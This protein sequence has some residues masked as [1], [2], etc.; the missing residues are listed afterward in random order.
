LIQQTLHDEIARLAA[1]PILLV[2]CDY[3]GT[4]A[5]IAH[6]PSA[7]RTDERSLAALRRLATLESTHAAVISGRARQD[8][9]ERLGI[10]P[11]LALIGGHGAEMGAPAPAIAESASRGTAPL[12]FPDTPPAAPTEPSP[13]TIERLSTEL[14]HIAADFPGA[15]VETKPS[16]AAFHYRKVDPESHARARELVR[17]AA[18]RLKAPVVREGT[19]VIEVSLVPTNKGRAFRWL[20]D[21]VYAH[22]AVFIGDDLTDEDAFAVLRPGDLGVK[23]GED[24]S[25]ARERIATTDDVHDLLEAL[26]IARE[27]WLARRHLP[28]IEDHAHLSDQRTCA[29]IDPHG[30]IVWLCAPRF[31]SPPIFA[32][33]LGG[34]GAMAGLA[35]SHAHPG[36]GAGGSAAGGGAGFFEI[37]P[38]DGRQPIRRAYEPDTFILKTEYDG[39]LTVTDYLD[40][41]AGRPYQRAGRSDL[42]RV[43]QA[44]PGSESPGESP[45]PGKIVIRFSPRIDFARS[46]T[47]LRA[48]A[49]GLVI[50]GMLDPAALYVPGLDWTIQDDGPNQTAVTTVDLAALPN[51]TLTLELRLGTTSLRV[52]Q[53]PEPARREATRY[54]WTAWAKP[55]R[56]PTLHTDLVKRSALVLKSLCYGPTGAICAAGT[57]SLPEQLGGVRN[58]DYRFCWVRDAAMS[59]A[60]L[61][62]LGSIGHALKYLDWLGGIL[63]DIDSPERL[64]PLYTVRAQELGPEGEISGLSGYGDSR[65]VRVGNGAAQQVQLDV[66]GA[67]ADLIA[68]LAEAGA[69]LTPEHWRMLDHM[70]RAVSLRWREP[71]HGIWEIRG[72]MRQHVHSKLMCWH[73]VARSIT[74]REITGEPVSAEHRALAEAIRDDILANGVARSKVAPGEPATPSHF[75]VAYDDPSVDAACLTVGLLGLVPHDDP[76]FAAT[77]LAVERE[78]LEN[79]TVLRYRVDDGLP[80]VEGGFHLC[81]GWLIESLHLIGRRDEARKLLDKYAAQCGPLG[82]YAEERCTI[83]G[84]S[85]GNYPQAYS[86]LALINACVRLSTT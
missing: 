82:L 43:V 32:Q 31:D 48:S 61:A 54:F 75:T 52:A 76:R 2:G 78:L 49:E 63:E 24:S 21:R 65:P 68:I 79:D 39:G 18:L 86:H 15:L 40:C 9:I 30:R 83:S 38:A 25:A 6:S 42:I 37:A 64:R 62:R 13:G 60:A 4:L 22:A 46:P 59:A 27:Q 57:A 55:L 19:M 23:V 8:L 10:T 28:A 12:T 36:G 51:N 58:W 33:I 85:L 34:Q 1:T 53:I 72:P 16:G 44:P 69:A 35:P 73:T 81:T 17:S 3:D 56:L 45:A 26:A 7:A 41:S 5:P 77:V 80:G 14:E 50:E 84:R 67:V 66:F 20:I 11:N 70:I 74:A 71:D 47:R 29:L